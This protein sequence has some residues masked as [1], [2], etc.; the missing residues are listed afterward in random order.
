[1]SKENIQ[2][3]DFN[4]F[5]NVA[6]SLAK[7]AEAAKFTVDQNGLTVYSKND[8]ARCE[9]TT[10]SI[11]TKNKVE[12][13]IGNLQ[14]FVKILQTVVDVHEN[15]FSDLKFLVD[16]PAIKF[17]SKKFKTK[18]MT[19]TESDTIEKWISKKLEAQLTPVFEFTTTSD[20]IKRLNNHSFIFT[21]PESLRIYLNIDKTMENN[22]LYATLGNNSNDLNNSLTMKFGLVTYGSL[23]DRQLTLDYNRLNLFNVIPSS[24]IKIQLMDKNVLLSTVKIQGKN[25]TFFNMNLYNS[26][27][28]A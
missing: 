9:I 23:G 16:M 6:K 3:S 27:R 14:T 20:I 5:N 12:F 4:L 7:F 15:D 28:K 13:N 24:D 19:C 25:D 22:V 18:L 17:E 11:T 26:L 1:M 2:I 21:N 10:N 8:W